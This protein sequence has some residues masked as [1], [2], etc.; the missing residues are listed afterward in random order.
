MRIPPESCALLDTAVDT[1]DSFYHVRGEFFH[2]QKSIVANRHCLAHL[3]A[4]SRDNM[5]KAQRALPVRGKDR[6]PP[7]SYNSALRTD[8]LPFN[9]DLG[10]TK[11]SSSCP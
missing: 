2:P 6:S 11:G 7:D 3:Y 9:A 5:A 4:R 8:F 1:P 10:R